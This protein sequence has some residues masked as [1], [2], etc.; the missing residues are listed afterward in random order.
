MLPIPRH[1]VE[2]WLKLLQQCVA[3][4]VR[5]NVQY[6]AGTM[7]IDRLENRVDLGCRVLVQLYQK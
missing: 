7:G 1:A 5:Q 6:D 3:Q 2:M 4:F